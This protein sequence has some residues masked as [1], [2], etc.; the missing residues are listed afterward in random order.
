MKRLFQ[1]HE[2][3]KIGIDMCQAL[4]HAHDRGVIHR[5]IKPANILL[6]QEGNVKLSDFGIA[7]FFGAQ[8]IT[9]VHTIIGTLEYMAPEQALGIPISSSSDIYSLGCV[10]YALLTC[11]PPFPARSLPE[12]LRKHRSND[13]PPIH[14]LRND[15]PDDLGYIIADML[16]IR[17]EDRP[18]HALLVVKRL[19]SLLHALMGNPDEI[20]VFPMSADTPKWQHESFAACSHGE[21]KPALLSLGNTDSNNADNNGIV[22][23]G[24]VGKP[25]TVR[26][27]GVPQSE[28]LFGSFQRL[29]EEHSAGGVKSVP[30]PPADQSN[31][32]DNVYS[33]AETVTAFSQEP[34]SE[35]TDTDMDQEDTL[36]QQKKS[37]TRFTAVT[38]KGYDP[39]EE[40]KTTRPL[41]SLP[42]VWASMALIIVGLTIYYL[43]Q[44]VPPEVLLKRITTK[45]QN[46]TSAENDIRKFILNYPDHSVPGHVQSYLDDVELAEHERR[47]ERRTQ[48]SA[49]RSLSPVE[50]AYV[51]VLTS[52]PNDPEQTIDRLRA[53]IAVFQTLPSDSATLT[54]PHRSFS[55]PVEVCVELARRRLEKLEQDFEEINAEQEQVLRRRLDEAAN[56][57]SK[58]PVRAEGIR[59]GIVKL[60]QNQRWAKE[61][62]EEAKQLLVE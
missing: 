44:P 9:E 39:F 12:L 56:L 50:R 22:D 46:G 34:L 28:S 24:K 3:A 45:I 11:K 54:H 29:G 41:L 49:Q 2:V 5:D 51:E 55:S 14:S 30:P 23:L 18:R 58:D 16:R 32:F 15:V 47:L 40:E 20:K 17:P 48:L 36:V 19:Q 8:Q 27:P 59:R 62:V 37:S 1:W 61:I 35:K 38:N 7:R 13:P 31:N 10:L 25:E 26:L 33:L 53:F 60:Y 42:T 52:S 6:D 43:L 4:R 21:K 57:D